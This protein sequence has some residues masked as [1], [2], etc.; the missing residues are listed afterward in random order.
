MLENG[1]SEEQHEIHDESIRQHETIVTRSKSE[2]QRNAT[3][4]RREDRIL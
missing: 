1:R 3:M 2:C 4:Q